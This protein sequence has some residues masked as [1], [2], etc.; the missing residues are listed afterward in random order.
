MTN[1]QFWHILK[2]LLAC[3]HGYPHRVRRTSTPHL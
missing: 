1:S 3:Q 2:Q